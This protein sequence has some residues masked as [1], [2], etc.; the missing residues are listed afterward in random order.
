MFALADGTILQINLPEFRCYLCGLWK[1]KIF[2]TI[3]AK[4]DYMVHNGIWKRKWQYLT[5]CACGCAN[6]IWLQDDV[7]PVNMS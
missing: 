5:K 3:V 7:V 2:I 1:E 4:N 6:H